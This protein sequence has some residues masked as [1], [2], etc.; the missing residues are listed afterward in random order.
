[1]KFINNKFKNAYNPHDL[2]FQLEARLTPEAEAA[3]QYLWGG[4]RI[5]GG[6]LRPYK[7]FGPEAD[8]NKIRA[9]IARMDSL[10]TKIMS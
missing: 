1:M 10:Q 9:G 4:Q 6:I 5:V 2:N 7:R 3:G 8:Q